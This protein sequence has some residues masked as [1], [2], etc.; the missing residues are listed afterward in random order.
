MNRGLK[1]LRKWHELY[2]FFK[3]K[4]TLVFFFIALVLM[5][6]SLLKHLFVDSRYCLETKDEF[7]DVF[8]QKINYRTIRAIY[9]D[10]YTSIYCQ[11]KSITYRIP[12]CAEHSK[13]NNSIKISILKVGDTIFKEQYKNEF[14]VIQNG[15]K[16]P[17]EIDTKRD[18]DGKPK[19]Y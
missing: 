11:Y 14:S 2:G 5:L 3:F 8:E 1:I 19:I 17:F 4:V 9:K 15:E 13:I 10:N 18:I 7:F 16:I 12:T 6:P